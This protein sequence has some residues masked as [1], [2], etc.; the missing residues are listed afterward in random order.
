MYRS[1]LLLV[2]LFL[3]GC[4]GSSDY[5]KNVEPA[6][7][8]AVASLDDSLVVFARPSG[9]G[10]AVQSPVFDVTEESPELIGIVS[11]KTRIAHTAAPGKHRYMVI[12]ESAAFLDAELLAGKTYYVTVSP[13]MGLWKA[14]F[15][16]APAK[17]E[18]L[19][20]D[21]CK[22]VEN[23][24]ASHAWA[25]ANMPSILEKKAKYLPDFLADP[26]RQRLDASDGE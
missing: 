20:C 1:I 8:K 24:P 12:G 25:T 26:E 10:F 15:A 6:Q 5:M 2:V 11:A 23:T 18:D 21:A 7:V 9:L 13:R 19:D 17:S 16:L 4:A 14:R 22:W 3:A